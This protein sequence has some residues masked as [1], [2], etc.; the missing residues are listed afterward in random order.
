MPVRIVARRD[1]L[2]DLRDM[3]VRPEIARDRDQHIRPIATAT[4]EDLLV[5]GHRGREV[6][7]IKTLARGREA[8]FDGSDRPARGTGARVRADRRFSR[9][10]RRGLLRGES[11]EKSHRASKRRGSLLANLFSAR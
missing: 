9:C 5:D 11:I 10:R 4:R 6:L 1:Q 2:D 3:P 7:D 8:G